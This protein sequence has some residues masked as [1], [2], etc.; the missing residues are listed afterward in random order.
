MGEP[1]ENSEMKRMYSHWSLLYSTILFYP[2]FLIAEA[3]VS[4]FTQ[5]I[6]RVLSDSFLRKKTKTSDI[7]VAVTKLSS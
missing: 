6:E 4:L 7:R 5:K 2:F 1:V 3:R